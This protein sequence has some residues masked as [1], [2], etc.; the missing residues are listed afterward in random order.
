MAIIPK[1][2]STFNNI[3]FMKNISID[4]SSLQGK[5]AKEI[6]AIL[7]EAKE[8]HIP[9]FFPIPAIPATPAVVENGIT[10]VPAKEATPAVSTLDQ[11]RSLPEYV[12]YKSACDEIT[13]TN[14]ANEKSFNENPKVKQI[15]QAKADAKLFNEANKETDDKIVALTKEVTTLMTAKFITSENR[16]KISSINKQIETLRD[17]ITYPENYELSFEVA[18]TYT[19][20]PLPSIDAFFPS[21]INGIPALCISGLSIGSRVAK[22][23]VATSAESAPTSGEYSSLSLAEKKELCKLIVSEIEK[24]KSLKDAIE[25]VSTSHPVVLSAPAST[26]GNMVYKIK[27]GGKSKQDGS[28]ELPVTLANYLAII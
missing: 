8:F 10:V 9:S 11:L 19:P 2:T 16:A 6:H 22:K 13:A 7:S 12:A 4:L 20:S 18:P 3:F 21:G 23:V 26:F 1:T 27:W 28:A 15:A 24:G 25:L 17:A 5:S 14:E